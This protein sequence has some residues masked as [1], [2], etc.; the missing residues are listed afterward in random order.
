MLCPEHAAVTVSFSTARK[1][2]ASFCPVLDWFYEIAIMMQQNIPTSSPHHTHINSKIQD[3]D[4][5]GN[6]RV[7]YIRVVCT[8]PMDST[9]P[10][11]IACPSFDASSFS[12]RPRPTTDERP[13]AKPKASTVDDVTYNR[14]CR[15]FK[16]KSW[17]LYQERPKHSV[18]L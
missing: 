18:G 3:R 7:R 9:L 16:Q 13:T 5:M 4:R 6:I 11:E 2:H 8:L 12:C 15:R 1:V 17:I 14:K 10:A